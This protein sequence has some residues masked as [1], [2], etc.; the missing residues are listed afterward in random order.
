MTYDGIKIRLVGAVVNHLLTEF[1]IPN[2]SPLFKNSILFDLTLPKKWKLT[3]KYTAPLPFFGFRDQLKDIVCKNRGEQFS[4][5]T[6]KAPPLSPFRPFVR[7]APQWSFPFWK[8]G[9]PQ[10][11][12]KTSSVFNT[13]QTKADFTALPFF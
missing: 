9:A 6:R 5:Q 13:L 11:G 7:H 2:F 8:T 1:L 3:Q 4:M 12:L 10:C